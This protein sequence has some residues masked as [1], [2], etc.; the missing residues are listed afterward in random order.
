M[1]APTAGVLSVF[2]ADNPGIMQSN[3]LMA[4]IWVDAILRFAWIISPIKKNKKKTLPFEM[5]MHA[6]VAFKSG[7]REMI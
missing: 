3:D 5:V 6:L 2:Q 4:R 1:P 7:L